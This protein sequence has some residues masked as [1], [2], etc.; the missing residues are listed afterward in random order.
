MGV[1]SFSDVRVISF[2][3]E[4]EIV[5]V[6]SFVGGGGNILAS[7]GVKNDDPVDFMRDSMLLGARCGSSNAI[8]AEPFD[9][10]RSITVT[11]AAEASECVSLFL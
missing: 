5:N 6:V 11:P 4:S 1:A 9:V 10:E 3:I 8:V 2:M 7:K